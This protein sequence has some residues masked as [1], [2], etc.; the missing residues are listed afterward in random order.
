MNASFNMVS[1]SFDFPTPPLSQRLSKE[2]MGTADVIANDEVDSRTLISP[3]RDRKH[4]NDKLPGYMR[5]TQQQRNRDS[6]A[7][8]SFLLG[9]GASKTE[10]KAEPRRSQRL[11]LKTNANEQVPSK[12]QRKPQVATKSLLGNVN[13]E[14]QAQLESRPVQCDKSNTDHDMHSSQGSDL[15]QLSADGSVLSKNN[16]SKTHA[17]SEVR[18]ARRR[19]S[20]FYQNSI[21]GNNT[22]TS[23]K[24]MAVIM[25]LYNCD[26]ICTWMATRASTM[27]EVLRLQR[28]VKS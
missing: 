24:P 1:P 12:R 11:H 14:E 27:G 9:Q 28:G 18:P 7:R 15:Q 13:S 4:T 21:L 23:L 2:N 19:R 22:K 8:K 20:P 5:S 26:L 10:S 17:R 6:P 3:S 25:T 16:V